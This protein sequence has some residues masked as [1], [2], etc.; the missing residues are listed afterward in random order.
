MTT[1]TTV[2]HGTLTAEAFAAVLRGAGVDA[3]ADVRRYPGSRRHPHIASEALAGWL[4][5]RGVAYEWLPELG[6]RRRG[7]PASPNAGI[8][9]PQLRAYADHM[10]TAEL[11]AGVDRL[12]GWATG[13]AA[14]VLCA[15]SVWWRCHRRLL[16]DHLVL[17]A[18]VTVEHL[19]HDGRRTAHEPT[20]EA[21]VVEGHVRYDVGAPQ[22][23]PDLR[24]RG[25]VRETEPPMPN[26]RPRHHG[27]D[28][29]GRP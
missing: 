29:A 22:P 17:V 12:L 24:P 25:P 16:A 20:A 1:I 21:R 27:A 2:G 10:A 19:F 14:A 11:A 9:N 3:V 6:G 13:R 23:L 5:D 7:D 28:G 4:S 8:R 26:H 15:E 18:G